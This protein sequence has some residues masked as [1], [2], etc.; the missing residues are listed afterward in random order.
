MKPPVAVT[1]RSLPRFS[2]GYVTLYLSGIGHLCLN[3]RAGLKAERIGLLVLTFRFPAITPQLRP[4]DSKEFSTCRG[5]G[6][7]PR[8]LTS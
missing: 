1:R 6:R 5:R 2:D 3:S 7:M 4:A 8:S